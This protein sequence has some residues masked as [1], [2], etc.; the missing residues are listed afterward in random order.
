M[1]NRPLYGGLGAISIYFYKGIK[2]SKKLTSIPYYALSQSKI[3]EP[4]FRSEINFITKFNETVDA[5]ITIPNVEM[6]KQSNDPIAVLHIHYRSESWLISV[7]MPI[8]NYDN[9]LTECE[10]ANNLSVNAEM[11]VSLIS[12]QINN[13]DEMDVSLINDQINN[14]A[15]QSLNILIQS[16]NEMGRIGSNNNTSVD[17]IEISDKGNEEKEVREQV[18]EKCKGRSRRISKNANA[19]EHNNNN[20][21]NNNRNKWFRGLRKNMREQSGTNKTRRNNNRRKWR[22]KRKRQEIVNIPEEKKESITE[23]VKKEKQE[24]LDIEKQA[25]TKTPKYKEYIEREYHTS[26]FI[27]FDDDQDLV[28]KQKTYCIEKMIIDLEETEDE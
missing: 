21:N 14:A 5:N 28:L 8:R 19:G 7:G 9:S 6:M 10:R 4:R 13:A 18:Y 15:N 3:I 12:D 20:N 24:A 25:I 16:F 27:E 22:K 2:A 26:D 23:V 17:V 1:R 11:D